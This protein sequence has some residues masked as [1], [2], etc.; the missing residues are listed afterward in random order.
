MKDVPVKEDVVL[1]LKERVFTDN[2][3]VNRC[4]Q[5]LDRAEIDYSLK[6]DIFDL[7][8]AQA[9]MGLLLSGLEAM[10]LNDDLYGA[11]AEVITA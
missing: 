4:F 3:I 11:L 7:I 10:E 2:E 5:I 6:E 1:Y 8:E 9:D